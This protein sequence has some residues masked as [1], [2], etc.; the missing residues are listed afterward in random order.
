MH[1]TSLP[2]KYCLIIAHIVP[3]G[4]VFCP[5]NWFFLYF[6]AFIVEIYVNGWYTDQCEHDLHTLNRK[7]SDRSFCRLLKQHP[8]KLFAG[9]YNCKRRTWI[10]PPCFKLFM[11]KTQYQ[12]SM[13]NNWTCFLYIYLLFFDRHYLTFCTIS[14]LEQDTPKNF[15]KERILMLLQNIL[16]NGNKFF[17]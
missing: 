6:I 16:I 2:V 9:F 14:N 1:P 15:S 7:C 17:I 3:I 11:N 13:N 4:L 10:F 12:T 5:Y 8:F